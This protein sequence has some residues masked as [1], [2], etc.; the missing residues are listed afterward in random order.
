MASAAESHAEPSAGQRRQPPSLESIRAAFPQLEILE[1][2]GAGGM[3]AVF[4]AR[5]PKLERWVA[6]KV[7]PQELAGA[8]GFADRFAREARLLAR[9]NHPNIVTVYDFGKSGGYY[10]LLMEYVNGVNLRQA[11]EAG[12]FSPPAALS[13]VPQICDALQFA[14]QEGILHRDIK[15][16]NLLLD[17][18][19]RIKIADFGIAKLIGEA[20]KDVTLTG[21]G[22]AVGTPHYMAPEQ[23]ERPR[24]VDQRADI[25]SLGVVFYELLTGELPIGR[26]APPSEKSAA[27]PRVDPIVL[28]AL[29]KERERR[30]RSA[31]EVKT[32]VERITQV[33]GEP[34]PGRPV[35][36]KRQ[37]V[38]DDFLLCNPA[39][40]RMGQAIT[41]Y[42]LIVSPLY[43]LF[44]LDRLDEPVPQQFLPALIHTLTYGILTAGDFAAVLLLFIGALKLRRLNR[45]G[46]DLLRVT[47]WFHLCLLALGMAALLVETFL[48]PEVV[49]TP[50]PVVE[51]LYST[52]GAGMIAFEIAALMWLRRNRSL[53]EELCNPFGA[54]PLDVN[55]P[56][57][58]KPPTAT[59]A[60]TTTPEKQRPPAARGATASAILTAISLPPG[61][62]MILGLWF[63]TALPASYDRVATDTLLQMATGIG[64]TVLP[65][66]LG[67]LL[68]LWGLQQIR[69]SG[70]CL[71]GRTRA[72]IGALG[73]PALILAG[74]TAFA[75]AK[76]V[77]GFLP[78]GQ[79]FVVK[80]VFCA[81]AALAA[82]T[83]LVYLSWRWAGAVPRGRRPTGSWVVISVAAF[84]LLAPTALVALVCASLPPLSALSHR[85]SAPALSTAGETAPTT[86]NGNGQTELQPP[87]PK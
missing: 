32:S 77:E 50:T 82:G 20:V 78:E 10:Y 71:R 9:L 18:K 23:L 53:L 14:H 46:A 29:E 35:Q 16:E 3:G 17:S 47:L 36:A 49:E 31:G 61:F 81:A 2:I 72:L 85:L 33:V 12:R 70:G 73:W 64:V 87:P 84:L 13:L 74:F 86:T 58:S 21:S 22:L 56:P 7:L 65:A 45:A 40:P 43:W 26:F 8:P 83:S 30:F 15:P 66:S 34:G 5:Q 52:I 4:K 38:G 63:T 19:G 24:E 48:L 68:G 25:Y 76:L 75:L 6:L 28:R 44:G 54:P 51:S 55:R 42:A 27:D 11:M 67:F 37:T 41:V 1:L 79:G 62:I 39:L 60:V 59:D 80:I 57:S 69:A